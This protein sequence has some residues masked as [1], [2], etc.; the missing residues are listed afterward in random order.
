M[1]LASNHKDQL[2][3]RLKADIQLREP[4]YSVDMGSMASGDPMLTVKNAAGS[5]IALVS[6]ARRSFSGFNV[7]AELSNSAAEGLPEHVAF[8]L[9]DQAQTALVS[10]KLA[11][12]VKNLG[13]S[14]VKLGFKAAPLVEADLVDA[15]VSAEIPNDARYGAVGQ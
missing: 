8:L 12:Y 3:K 9:I 1:A 5:I 10:T 14:S 11:M 6:V 7:V 13:T 15:N 4:T 2:A